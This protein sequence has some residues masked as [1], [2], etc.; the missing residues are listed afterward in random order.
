MLIKLDFSVNCKNA[1]YVYIMFRQSKQQ[2]V[3]KEAIRKFSFHEQPSK[4]EVGRK[5]K[6]GET[7]TN[8]SASEPTQEPLEK[9]P[10]NENGKEEFC[11]TF[12]KVFTL[13]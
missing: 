8:G 6:R 11:I 7:A 4:I 5:Y 1:K 10:L 9:I 3:F 2:Q 12:D 13:L